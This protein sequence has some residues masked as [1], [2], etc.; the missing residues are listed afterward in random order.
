M[1]IGSAADK[2]LVATAVVAAPTAPWWLEYLN[3]GG[4]SV[5]IACG[6]GVGILRLMI[7][8]R[9]WRNGKRD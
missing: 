7:A 3:Y 8:W 6:A 4:T 1:T 2:A 5:V 9:D